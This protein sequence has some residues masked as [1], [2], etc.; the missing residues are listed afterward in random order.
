LLFASDAKMRYGSYGKNWA[1]SMT[2]M[3]AVRRS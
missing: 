3:H 1:R 2:R